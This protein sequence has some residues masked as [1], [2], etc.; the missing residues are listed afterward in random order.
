MP[1]R[2]ATV[3]AAAALLAAVLGLRVFTAFEPI[4]VRAARTPIEPGAATLE[5][6]L[7][8]FSAIHA[9]EPPV[10]VVWRVA[11][12]G[13]APA[14]LRL[15]LDG[16]IVC[17]RSVGA[18]KTARLDCAVP[19]ASWASTPK[20]AATV[21]GPPSDWRLLDLEIS[22]HHGST[23]S[24]FVAFVVPSGREVPRPSLP[25]IAVAFIVAVAVVRLKPMD[26]GGGMRTLHLIVS[27]IAVAVAALVLAGP[28][29]TPYKVILAPSAWML[30]VVAVSWPRLVPIAM[31]FPRLVR[32]M[33][34]PAIAHA[35]VVVLTAAAALRVAE[36][37]V[38][39]Y[40]QGNYSGFVHISRARFDR[41]PVLRTRADIRETLALEDGTGY[42][43]QFLYFA[44]FD[45]LLREIPNASAHRAFIDA[46]PYRYSR[47]AFS[48]LT[49][50]ASLDRWALYPMA[51]VWLVAGGM[52]AAA[53]G[54]AALARHQ[55]RS[56][57]W[58]L[59]VLVMPGM[60]RSLHLALPEPI[61]AAL[62]T[63]AVLCLVRE[64][65]RWAAL[66]F[67]AALLVRETAAV[68]VLAASASLFVRGQRRAGAIVLA[69]LA[70]LA[71]WRLYVAW[72]LFPDWGVRGFAFNPGTLG[73]PGKG[74]VEMLTNVAQGTYF[75]G[76]EAPAASVFF[77]AL[78]VAAAVLAFALGR[79]HPGIVTIT[80]AAYGLMA[81]SVDREK[82][83]AHLINVE[84][85]SYELFL[86]L[87]LA[88]IGAPTRRMRILLGVFWLASAAY[89]FYL[90]LDVELMRRALFLP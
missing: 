59:L 56:P 29:F 67:A 87:A 32:L 3:I 64:R 38:R 44:V 41:H 82:V 81:L 86:F 85:T 63:A 74:L 68:A 78:I 83:W 58:G 18:G 34:R 4:R 69:A 12:T 27:G 42:D 66:W 71:V 72:R 46:P 77:A 88:M 48:W 10:A 25:W 22:S 89:V 60:W 2:H 14:T 37:E 47:M 8:R 26:L 39:D 51:M 55:G 30:C 31:R 57:W 40:H 6:G 80:A 70:P 7:D 33:R 65:W 20:R 16:Q 61:V 28:W 9:L 75:P 54:L 73:I 76:T 36:V 1:G 21:S 84:R 23:A 24:P 17:E 13:A 53:G 5:V 15:A 79:R 62:L 35:A 50:A 52:A 49:K 11:N 45:P 43:G 19:P 90:G